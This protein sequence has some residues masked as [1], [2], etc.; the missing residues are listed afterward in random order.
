M[1]PG[2]RMR[3]VSAGPRLFRGD[4]RAEGRTG[5]EDEVMKGPPDGYDVAVLREINFRRSHG[6]T[7]RKT[8]L[9]HLSRAHWVKRNQVRE[10]FEVHEKTAG[11]NPLGA[12]T[13]ANPA[14]GGIKP[15]V[16]LQSRAPKGL[17]ISVD[18]LKKQ[19][20]A[21]NFRARREAFPVP[22]RCWRTCC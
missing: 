19:V 7:S 15:L 6:Q 3:L 17:P 16:L 21:L 11:H 4:N 14:H 22:V 18:F 9:S 8:H 20:L 2:R 12:G 5:D 10:V 1:R 13:Q